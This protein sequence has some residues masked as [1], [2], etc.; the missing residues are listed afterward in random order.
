VKS[1]ILIPRES[2]IQKNPK[3]LIGSQSTEE[4]LSIPHK[5]LKMNSCTLVPQERFSINHQTPNICVEV[6]GLK[7]DTY[8]QGTLPKMIWFIDQKKCS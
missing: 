4:D 6:Q 7:D 2:L 5:I 3:A 1:S 8:D